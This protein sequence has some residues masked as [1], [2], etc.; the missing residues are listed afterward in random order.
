M[1]I[2]LENI[3]KKFNRDWI[4]RG[5]SMQLKANDHTVLLGSNGSGKS[6]LLQIL[7]GYMEP[8]EGKLVFQR[9]DTIS[10][11]E[12]IFPLV[13]YTGP[14]L[15]LY[16][17]LTLAEI[18]TFHTRFKKL[19][20]DRKASDLIYSTGLERHQN[21]QLKYFSSGMLQRVKLALAILSK[22]PLLLLDEPTSNL[23]R[24][25]IDWY[26]KLMEENKKDRLALVCSNRQP[27]EYDFCS[28][29]IDIEAYK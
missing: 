11:A 22:T 27:E 14:N 8:S 5:I 24:Q 3:G 17:E 21:K 1:Q 10:G 18:T 12:E 15:K 28:N 19:R 16:E 23:D 13:S 4:F 25:G 29:S 6:T 2:T 20:D 9:G 26:K 7:S